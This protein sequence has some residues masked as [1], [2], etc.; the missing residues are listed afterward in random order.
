MGRCSTELQVFLFECVF[1]SREAANEDERKNSQGKCE[2]GRGI[3]VCISFLFFSP[4]VISYGKERR[5]RG[6]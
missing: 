4:L 5:V 6:R 1:M 3:Q 2:E